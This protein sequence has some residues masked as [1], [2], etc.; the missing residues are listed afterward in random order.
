M[1]VEGTPRT[2]TRPPPDGDVTVAA[3]TCRADDGTERLI[4]VDG[5]DRCDYL[6]AR[7]ALALA[8]ALIAASD[9]LAPPG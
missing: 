9:E 3:F 2:I 8:G 7:E 5:L 1:I 4:R 6:N